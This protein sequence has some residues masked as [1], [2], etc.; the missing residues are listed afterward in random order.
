MSQEQIDIPK[1]QSDD[2]RC[3]TG[4]DVATPTGTLR[5]GD[6]GQSLA[7]ADGIT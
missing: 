6:V 4:S 5:P 2:L 3:W 7:L 1:N